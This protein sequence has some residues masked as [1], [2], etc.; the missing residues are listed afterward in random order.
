MPIC[1]IMLTSFK[2]L[3]KLWNVEKGNYLEFSF[4]Y[5][6]ALCP[7]STVFIELSCLNISKSFISLLLCVEPLQILQWNHCRAV[8]KAVGALSL[9]SCT[10]SHACRSHFPCATSTTGC[11]PRSQTGRE[12][13]WLTERNKGLFLQ[14]SSW[15][16]SPC[17]STNTDM[18]RGRACSLECPS[19]Q[20]QPCFVVD[21]SKPVKHCRAACKTPPDKNNRY[22]NL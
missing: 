18:L 12:Q 14:R 22:L 2:S 21:Y 11:Q 6:H 7:S 8:N 3:L 16:S 5:K 13:T 19:Q 20:Q 1:T 15:T 4:R 10:C 17:S 9:P